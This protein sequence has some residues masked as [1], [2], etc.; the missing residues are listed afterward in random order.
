MIWGVVTSGDN[1]TISGYPLLWSADPSHY[2][3][4]TGITASINLW[5]INMVVFDGM[6][7]KKVQ[8]KYWYFIPNTFCIILSIAW[9]QVWPPEISNYGAICLESRVYFHNATS[10]ACIFTGTALDDVF[11]AKIN[12]ATYNLVINIWDSPVCSLG[13]KSNLK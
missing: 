8:W 7:L 6:L 1:L 10:P 3:L 2:N 5:T 13:R 9:H 4:L 11:P 12:I